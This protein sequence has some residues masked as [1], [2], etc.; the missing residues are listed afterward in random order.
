MIK[1]KSFKILAPSLVA[2]TLF[3]ASVGLTACNPPEVTVFTASAFTDGFTLTNTEVNK[4]ETYET[5]V[6]TT[7]ID[8]VT[9]NAKVDKIIAGG[10]KL[11]EAF[12]TWDVSSAFSAILTVNAEKVTGEITVSFTC[13]PLPKTFVVYPSRGFSLSK[14]Q[15]KEGENFECTVSYDARPDVVDIELINAE[16]HG[17]DIKSYT[18]FDPTTK[19]L[20]IQGPCITG[21]VV[22]TFFAN[23]PHNPVV[24]MSNAGFT[25]SKN[26]AEPGKEFKCTVTPDEDEDFKL[27]SVMVHG[28]DQTRFCQLD[29]NELTINSGSIT[30]YDIFVTFEYDIPVA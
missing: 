9:R 17:K 15:A 10:V 8:M 23:V 4:N 1:K 5:E 7:D 25:L 13:D 21:D 11:E 12:Y 18:N 6:T 30:L 28:L 24:V 22:L 19:K 3:G 27:V 16:V 14:T 2:S 29:G 26:T 20:T